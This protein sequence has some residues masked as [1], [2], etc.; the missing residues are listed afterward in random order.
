MMARTKTELTQ[1]FELKGWTWTLDELRQKAAERG[2]N[3]NEEV[4]EQAKRHVLGNCALT[5]DFA[6]LLLGAELLKGQDEGMSR[7]CRAFAGKL[8]APKPP[9]PEPTSLDPEIAESAA[10][11]EAASGAY[12]TVA[13][14]TAEARGRRARLVREALESGERD[15]ATV[16]GR[17][18]ELDGE[19]K[20]CEQL[21]LLA[22]EERQR[23]LR[24]HNR[25]LRMRDRL[26]A[27]QRR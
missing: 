15:S 23:L 24:E 26:R 20:E 22:G 8:V 7:R 10:A 19:I 2:C 1:S 12:D 4:I 6:T 16:R 21:K 9:E 14:R 5:D 27:L 17:I 18:A 3:T 25:L 11:L 13:R